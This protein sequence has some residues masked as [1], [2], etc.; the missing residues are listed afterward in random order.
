[1]DP[2]PQP[3]PLVGIA[4]K[5]FSTLCFTGMAT[6]VK[7]ASARYPIGEVVF[8]RSFFALIPV[9][10]WVAYRRELS[11]VMYTQ[12]IGRHVLR[13]VSGSLTM[14]CGFTA[15]SLLPIADAVAISYATPLLTVVFAVIFLGE[16]VRVYRWTAVVVGLFGVLV[17]LSDYVA[18]DG[19]GTID[20]S[21]TGALVAVLAAVLGAAT[22]TQVRAMVRFEPVP[23][24]V[25]YFTLFT[26][27]AGLFTLP[28]GWTM[29]D[30]FD[31]AMLVTAGILGGLGQVALTQ[32]FLHGG[33]SLIAPFD[34]VSMIWTLVVSVL[35]FSTWPTS[36]M[37][38]GTAIVIAA[39]LFMI[40]REHRLGIERSRSKRAQTPGSTV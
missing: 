18:T 30:P 19:G 8:F 29:P 36:T 31:F 11:M 5:V 26:T 22:S 23:T 34:Y 7:L 16:V 14:F 2:S 33:A 35:V 37:L 28:F 17:I 25:V 38:I 27:L 12:N 1:M 13:G 20:R 32:S 3:R 40:F 10:I 39:G 9:V 4:L 6:L 15:L 24:I 21:V